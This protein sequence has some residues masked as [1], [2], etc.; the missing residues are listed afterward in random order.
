MN[1]L[2]I[3]VAPIASA[4]ALAMSPAV[5]QTI[6]PNTYNPASVQS[7]TAGPDGFIVVKGIIYS[8][9]QGRATVLPDSLR[10]TGT[11]QGVNGFPRSIQMLQPG[12][13]LTTEGKIVPAPQN[14]V[15]SSNAVGT[16]APVNDT[17]NAT[18]N[19]TTRSTDNSTENRTTR[20][21]D[22]SV[23]NRTTRAT[24]NA[25]DNRTTRS[26]NNATDNRTTNG[27]PR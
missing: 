22:N 21:T 8:V 9:R 19:S 10:W 11:T 15:F 26:T 27:S 5:G 16:I 13:M 2:I 7:A 1:S 14:V 12:F 4:L 23:D 18:D 3:Y 25:T 24:S 20:S 17:N 6:P